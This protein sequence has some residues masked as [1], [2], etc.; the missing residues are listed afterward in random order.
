M[1]RKRVMQMIDAEYDLLECR[2]CQ[3][4]VAPIRR[5]GRLPRGSWECPC[6]CKL[7]DENADKN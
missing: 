4:R 2:I 5:N 1:T 6:G 3:T 7:E